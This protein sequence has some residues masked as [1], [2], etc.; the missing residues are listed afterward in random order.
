MYLQ[1]STVGVQAW[2]LD[3]YGE[4]DILTGLRDSLPEK[5]GR[6]ATAGRGTCAN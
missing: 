4:Q 2:W 1:S 6:F 5:E 3:G